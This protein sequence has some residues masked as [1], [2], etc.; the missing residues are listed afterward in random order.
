[1]P[2][3]FSDLH[4]KVALVTGVG[5]V[6]VPSG[7]PNADSIW[8]NGAATAKLLAQT[9]VRVFGCDLNIDAAQYTKSR[10]EAEIPGAQIEVVRTDVTK[11][12]EVDALAKA[13][14]DKYGSIDVLVCNVGMSAP[15]SP[16]DMSDEVCADISIP[17]MS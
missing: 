15:G 17:S 4:N 12:A 8:G 11:R 16:V 1:M 10:I 7:T 3:T 14:V 2:I 6:S 9:G 13:C 5:Q